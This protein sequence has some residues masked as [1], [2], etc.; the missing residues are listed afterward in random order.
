MFKL[1]LVGALLVVLWYFLAPLFTPQ[2][3]K[4]AAKRQRRKKFK[5]EVIEI[6]G[7]VKEE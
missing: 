7:K 4:D 3:I 2:S 1:I 6:K 5:G